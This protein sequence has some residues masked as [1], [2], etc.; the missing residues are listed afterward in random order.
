MDKKFQKNFGVKMLLPY[1]CTPKSWY[2]TAFNRKLIFN[3][4]KE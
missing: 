4:W 3:T 2:K 1:F